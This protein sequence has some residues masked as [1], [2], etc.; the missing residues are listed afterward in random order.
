MR[1]GALSPATSDLLGSIG[2][3][4]LAFL[5]E[6]DRRPLL[7]QITGKT[8]FSFRT[9]AVNSTR[10]VNEAL[11]QDGELVARLMTA[12]KQRRLNADL[13]TTEITTACY[14]LAIGFACVVDVINPGDRQTPGTFFE[15]LIKHLI[16]TTAE[17]EPTERVAVRVGDTTIRL[18]LDMILA[19][20]EGTTRFH[21][22]I[23][24]STRERASEFWAHQRIL[25]HA[26]GE[27]AYLGMFIGLGE[28]K[29]D[30]KRYAVV[31]ICV[32]DQWRLYQ[33][34]IATIHRIYYLD[35]PHAYMQLNQA[36]PPLSVQ[37]FG[38]YFSESPL[39]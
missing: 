21:V 31:E 19:P 7:S 39:F 37:P 22:A 1:A 32:P 35:P 20:I 2:E 10:P 6:M 28:T 16:A 12:A 14:T 26:F 5:R 33:A 13:S 29:L 36:K 38:A 30:H 9:A 8:F 3:T 24:T 18:T 15:Y 17:S 25:D 34:H 23:K 27:H 4:C 11:F